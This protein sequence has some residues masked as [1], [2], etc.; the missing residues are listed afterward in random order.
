MH[1]IQLI[2][3]W[4]NVLSLSFLYDVLINPRVATDHLLMSI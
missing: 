2:L 3:F 4:Q 1:Y